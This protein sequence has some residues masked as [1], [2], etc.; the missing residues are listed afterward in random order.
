M[1]PDPGQAQRMR[2]MLSRMVGQLT[3]VNTADSP[4]MMK[5]AFAA[6]SPFIPMLPRMLQQIPDETA[7][8]MLVFVKEQVALIE[9]DKA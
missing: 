5:M 1:T 2:D 6:L 3:N 7:C 8:G 4:P 9:G